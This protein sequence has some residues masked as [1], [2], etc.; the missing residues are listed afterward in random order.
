VTTPPALRITCAS[1]SLSPRIAYT[2]IRASM[3]AS[4]ATFLA[5]RCDSAALS[6]LAA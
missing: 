6:K 2:L 3:H 1:P 4:T 5:G